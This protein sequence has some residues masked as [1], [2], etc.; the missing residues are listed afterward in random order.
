MEQMLNVSSNPHV[1][2]KMTTGRIMQL[3]VLALLPTTL[4]GIWNF[5]FRAFLVV[6]VTVASSVFFEWLYDRLM[7]KKNTVTDFSAAVTGLLLALNMP[8]QIPLWMPVL[9]SAFAIIVVKQLFGGLGQNFMNPA[10]AARCFL[11]ISFTGKMTDFAVDKLSGYH[12]IDT[13]TGAT[14]LAELKNSGFTADSI[15]VKNLFIGNIHGTIGETSALAILIGAVILLAFK[16]IDLKIPLTYIGSFAVFVIFYMLGTGKGFDVNYLFSHLF[17]GGLMLGAW[18]MATDY[19]TTPIT[20]KGQLIYGCCL[21]VVTAIF[22]LFGGSAE[23][24]SY[25]IIFCNL[26]VPLIEK[27]TKPV[28]FG[29]GGKKA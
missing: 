18:F 10:L 17:G 11:M 20:P 21:G 6:L 5:G 28:A 13:V 2:D 23:G 1:R 3:V 16:V 12:C 15:S 26:L 14:A 27:V 19:V 22:R 8:P 24:V 25:A 9:G 7:H 29:K 4:F